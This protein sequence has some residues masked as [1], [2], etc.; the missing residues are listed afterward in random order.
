MKVEPLNNAEVKLSK[1]ADH[2]NNIHIHGNLSVKDFHEVCKNRI[3]FREIKNQC[4]FGV[5]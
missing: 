2:A 5:F 4:S 3:L 1:L